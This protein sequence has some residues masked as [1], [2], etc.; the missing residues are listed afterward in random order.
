M[1]IDDLIK[2]KGGIQ[3]DIG[4]GAHKQ[5]P[6]W[7]GLDIQELSG[8]DIVW[9]WNVK[10][11]PMPDE[12]V[13]RAIA[14]HVVEHIP[15]VSLDNGKTRFPFIE[16]MDEVWRVMKP[17]GEFAIAAPHGA[18]SGYLQ[19]PTHCNQVNEFTWAYFDKDHPFYGFYKPKPWR[20]KFINWN[21]N[22]N[23]EVVLTKESETE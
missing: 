4:C 22:L 2:D 8:V 3:L 7:V 16:F 12:C 14:S 21:P 5:G 19:D 15:P 18:S 17:G 20:V 23:I 11:W 6:E 10:P 13:L 9:D 1:N